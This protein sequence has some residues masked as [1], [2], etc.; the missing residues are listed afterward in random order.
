MEN[1]VDSTAPQDPAVIAKAVTIDGFI[2]SI[3]KS[4]PAPLITQLP[5]AIPDDE[6]NDHEMGNTSEPPQT[7]PPPRPS[8]FTPQCKSIRLAKKSKT[9]Q[10]K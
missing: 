1:E 5:E 7:P 8:L 6:S 3:T 9:T 10:G 4:I 2:A